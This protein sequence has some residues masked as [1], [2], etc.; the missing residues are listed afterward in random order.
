VL[1]LI[2]QY[3]DANYPL[4]LPDSIDAIKMKMQENGLKNKEQGR[5]SR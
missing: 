3:E 2:K 4:P 1:L 5:E